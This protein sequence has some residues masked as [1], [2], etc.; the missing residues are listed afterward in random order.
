M[1]TKL[2]AIGTLLM[3]VGGMPSAASAQGQR[4][5]LII[6][7]FSPTEVQIS[8][9]SVLGASYQLSF[10]EY[11]DPFALWQPIDAPITAQSDNT[12]VVVDKGA[13]GTGFFRTFEVN[14]SAGLPAVSILS[15]ANGSPES[16]MITVGVGAADDSRLSAVTLYLDGVPLATSGDTSFPL[17]TTHFPNGSHQLM[18]RAADNV[19]IS[20]L[21]GNPDSLVVANEAYSVPITLIFQNDLRWLNADTLFETHVPISAQSD[22]FPTTW[23]VFVEN[24]A[25][26]VVRT[27]TG[28]TSDG[29]IET[30][31]DGNDNN[32]LPLPEEAIY[33]VTL[34][35]GNPAAPQN[36]PPGGGGGGSPPQVQAASLNS[37][38]VL[39]YEVEEELAPLPKDFF[40]LN[41]QDKDKSNKATFE[42]PPLPPGLTEGRD[43]A[44]KVKKKLSIKELFFALSTSAPGA[45][46]GSSS[47]FVWRE[48]SWSS[49]QI[50]LARQKYRLGAGLTFNASLASMLSGVATLIEAA[51]SEVGAGRSVLNGNHIEISTAAGYQ[52]LLNDLKRDDVRDF[53][54]HGHSQGTA[55]GFSEFTPD[56]GLTQ[57]NIMNAL[58]NRFR[59]ATPT[60]P[61][62]IFL[63]KKPFRFVFL[64]GCLSATAT[65]QFPEA[66]GIPG[67]TVSGKKARA[68][69]GW[70][71][72]TRNSIANNDYM[73]FTRFFWEKWLNEEEGYNLQLQTA[74][75]AAFLQA[76]T[77]NP[78]ALKILGSN[79]LT[80]RE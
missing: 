8:W 24:E 48:K 43:K 66:F 23:T 14:E 78:Q 60:D 2:T 12:A 28:S 47:A 72:T 7:N 45:G 76:P 33:K 42:L 36:P 50:I 27:F 55:I 15:P 21:G 49:A 52:T 41:D 26:T 56:D 65:G 74:V 5:S 62:V 67:F 13:Y 17:D 18:A 69:M 1:K 57:N 44:V 9:N 63:I 61:R 77:A 54:Y 22:V 51:T 34:A 3:L 37:Y 4:P 73:K 35:I 40:H 39:E 6:D 31:W 11:I 16:G 71:T 20:Y 80:W 32:G 38:G 79:L 70:S 30:E 29:T 53:Y 64:D 46:P 10:T 68:F 58:N 59:K 25:G 19:G 75:D